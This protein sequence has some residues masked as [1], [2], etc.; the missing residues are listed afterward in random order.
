[1]SK[2]NKDKTPEDRTINFVSDPCPTCGT[3]QMIRE[4]QT[5]EEATAD[6]FSRHGKKECDWSIQQNKWCEKMEAKPCP[7]CGI[8]GGGLYCDCLWSVEKEPKKRNGG[9]IRK[10]KKTRPHKK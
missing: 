1:M 9:A 3:V 7:K 4:G 8:L 6:F 10:S 2:K 5:K